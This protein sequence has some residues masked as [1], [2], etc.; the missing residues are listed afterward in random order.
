M[1]N[2]SRK[3]MKIFGSEAGPNEIAKFGSFAAGSPEYSTDPAIIQ[4]LGNY[5][6]GWVAAVD[7]E[8]YPALEDMN[9]LQYLFSYQLAYI[10]QKG[11]PEYSSDTEYFYGSIVMSAGLLYVSTDNNNIGNSLTTTKWYSFG[12]LTSLMSGD[13]TPDLTITDFIE[14]DPTDAS[15]TITLPA[16]STVTRGKKITIKNIAKNGNTVTIVGGGDMYSPDEIDNGLPLV[17]GSDPVMDSV[18]LIRG[19]SQWYVI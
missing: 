11:I 3:I 7:G 8:D 1:A 16:I 19:E 15:F 18:T 5:L 10:M 14:A 4:E 12:S 13:G 9:A 6:K 17:L 2:L